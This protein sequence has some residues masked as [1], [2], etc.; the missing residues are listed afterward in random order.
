MGRRHCFVI[1][2]E[3]NG[4]YSPFPAI[5]GFKSTSLKFGSNL[6]TQ[7]AKLAHG[8]QREPIFA[9][10]YTFYSEK[11]ENEKGAFH[12]LKW[13]LNPGFNTAEIMMQAKAT[14]EMMKNVEVKYEEGMQP[15]D[16]TT[17]TDSDVTI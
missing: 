14:R 1:R 10:N 6:L 8:K 12:L 17:L 2:R 11:T 15:G 13:R 7:L 3:E 16:E 9:R 4:D 5:I